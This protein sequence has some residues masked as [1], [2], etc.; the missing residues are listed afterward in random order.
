MEINVRKD[1]WAGVTPLC[2]GK[3]VGTLWDTGAMVSLVTEE[4]ANKLVKAGAHR[5]GLQHPMELVGIGSGSIHA[6]DRLQITLTLQD[7]VD[8][9]LIAYVVPKCN[10]DII[11]G[12]DFMTQQGLGL[13]SYRHCLKILNGLKEG[14]PIIHDTSKERKRIDTWDEYVKKKKSVAT[15]R[16]KIKQKRIK[17]SENWWQGITPEDVEFINLITSVSLC[18]NMTVDTFNKK[19]AEIESKEV[20]C[21][22]KSTETQN[23][24]V[25]EDSNNCV[26]HIHK[27]EPET[28]HKVDHVPTPAFPEMEKPLNELLNKYSDVFSSTASDTGK[29]SGERVKIQLLN[30]TPVNVRNYRTPLKLRDVLTKI[31]QE[32]MD[33]GIIERCTESAYNA[34]C[35]LIPKKT[36]NGISAGHRIVVDYRQLNKV[37]KNVVYPMP[38]I[39]DILC[40]YG[41]C[42]IFSVLDIRHAFY[43]IAI[44]QESKALT[45][46]SCELGKFQYKFLPQGLKISPAIFQERIVK[47]L[48]GVPR[49]GPYIDDILSGERSQELHLK[50]LETIFLRLREAGFKL[51]LSKCELCRKRVTF[52][53]IDVT[54]EGC[55]ITPDKLNSTKKLIKPKTQ[56][57]VKSLLGFTSFLR[58]YV[59]HYCDIVGPI[60]SL[61]RNKNKKDTDI[62][63]YWTTQHDAAFDT[64]KRTLLDSSV[65]AFPDPSKP[66]ELFTDASKFHMSGVLMQQDKDNNRRPI[67]YWSKSFKNEQINWSALVKEARAVFEGVTHFSVFIMGCPTVIRC[68]HKPLSRFL[69]CQTKND[70]VNRWSMALQ[71]FDLSFEWV[72]SGENISDCLSHLISPTELIKNELYRPHDEVEN[73][74][75]HGCQGAVKKTSEE[76]RSENAAVASITRQN[77]V[78]TPL[79]P[80]PEKFQETRDQIWFLNDPTIVQAV[81]L[82]KPGED[83]KLVAV[84]INKLGV[85]RLR[86]LQDLDVACR[87]I[88]KQLATQTD[89]NG[90]FLLQDNVLYRMHLGDSGMKSKR[91]LDS[92]VLVIPRS[93]KMTVMLNT[94]LELMHAGRDRML[95]TLERRVYWR[96]M[97]EDIRNFV[98]GCIQCRQRHLIKPKC[99]TGQT[100]PPKAPFERLAIDIW[101]CAK[102]GTAVTVIDLHSQYP[103]LVPVP[104][105]SAKSAITAL[106]EVLGFIKDPKE[107]LSD[108][109]KEFIAEEFET[110]LK[111]RDIVHQFTNPYQPQGN[112]VLEKWHKFLNAAMKLCDGLKSNEDWTVTARAALESYRK[113]PHTSTA[114]TP[115]FLAFGL[116]PTYR[117]DKLLP[118]IPKNVWSSARES[119]DMEAL[120]VTRHMARH[121]TILAR[122]R[123][124][125]KPSQHTAQPLR[126]GDRVWRKIHT[127]TKIEEA[128]K[129]GYRVLRFGW[130]KH[131][132]F[133][134]DEKTNKEHRVARKDLIKIDPVLEIIRNTNI[135]CQPGRSL[136]YFRA[137]DLPDLGWPEIEGQ[138][139]ASPSDRFK[140]TE[141]TR[142]RCDDYKPQIRAKSPVSEPKPSGVRGETNTPKPSRVRVRPKHLDDYIV[143]LCHTPC[144][145]QKRTNDAKQQVE[146]AQLKANVTAAINM[147]RI[148]KTADTR[149]VVLV[150]DKVQED[151]SAKQ[152]IQERLLALGHGAKELSR[153]ISNLRAEQQTQQTVTQDAPLQ[154]QLVPPTHAA[155]ANMEMNAMLGIEEDDA[156][157]E[158]EDKNTRNNMN[159]SESALHKVASKIHKKRARRIRGSV[160][161]KRR[162]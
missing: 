97:T 31:L 15:F 155:R 53:G 55:M 73:D 20:D 42:T 63:K 56:S 77:A 90:R 21:V 62:T 141:I 5:I 99:P 52:T 130:S 156:E 137:G 89:A 41:G 121:N 148:T 162:L 111:N 119:P 144:R 11:V 67:G 120:R 48:N 39:Q 36:E 86:E 110:F 34:P 102:R 160:F 25:N 8:R 114:E 40:D 50:Q 26:K 2:N 1:A 65:L 129:E 100:K 28:Q 9:Q 145:A 143:Y 59:P 81:K 19:I 10:Y 161:R 139:D 93:L 3:E 75:P 103:F 84:N 101:K 35:M 153:R 43:T 18:K 113:T 17:R 22:W 30:E 38:R 70:M 135:D 57:D 12:L 45:S 37:V 60:Q 126:E 91:H 134:L 142:N 132:V 47:T 123:N 54:P 74:F 105:K 88:K 79:V 13:L 136:L 112:A 14:K 29:Y 68:D 27:I 107:I 24:V 6:T 33:A 51:K 140:M 104:D 44:D 122:L 4:I 82:I 118:T 78:N 117:I 138:A 133:I 154:E 108:N 106:S 98:A 109:G 16:E 92:L 146:A 149:K 157:D 71:E 83:D 124:K 159:Y 72:S 23:A 61:V 49:V 125:K 96:G 131:T 69:A 46:F 158:V 7:G 147:L 150:N 32:L 87:R 95:S 80:P 151:T 94:H 115:L 152:T 64:L 85:D 127:A 58:A 116:E 128:W 66:Y 76:K